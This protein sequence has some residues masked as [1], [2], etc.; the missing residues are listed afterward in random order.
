MNRN[1]NEVIFF[2]F[3]IQTFYEM[4]DLRDVLVLATFI[5]IFHIANI[6]AKF[7]ETLFKKKSVDVGVYAV[8]RLLNLH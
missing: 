3:A 4:Q 5:L 6:F 2:K 1:S 7:M 8:T